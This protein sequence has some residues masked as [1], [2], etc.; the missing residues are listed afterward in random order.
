MSPTP[1]LTSLL[2][3]VR[4]VRV[5]PTTLTDRD[6]LDLASTAATLQHRA[7]TISALLA[8]EIARRSVG[9]DGLAQRLG[10]RTAIELVRVTTGSTGRDAAVAVRVGSLTESPVRDALVEGTISPSAADAI[11]T[12][13]GTPTAAVSADELAAA[14]L[15]LCT[16]DLDPD[17]LQRRA[18][19]VRAELDVTSIADREEA[20]RDARSLR[21][22]RQT[23]GMSK[24]IWLMDPETAATV[25]DVFDRATSPRLG[26]PRF[27]DPDTAAHAAAI[28]AD[29][30]T[31]EQLASDVFTELLRHGAAADSTQLLGSGAPQIRVLVAATALATGIGAATIEGQTEP[32][33]IATVERLACTG[34]TT[35]ITFANGQPLDVGRE[36][37]LYTPRQRIA[38]AARDGG[39]RWPRCDRPPSWTEAHHINHWAR[40]GGRTDVADG[41]LLCR[42]HHLQLHNRGW[43]IARKGSTYTLT[44]PPGV[45]RA[46]ELMPTKARTHAA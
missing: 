28:E 2:E 38:L 26:G 21:F 25:G 23:D 12:G 36:H 15:E 6:L 41:I 37:R 33:S 4:C 8:G 14:S 32:I 43:T 9:S 11:V 16:L 22:I 27:V 31:N 30:R 44:P 20:L 1:S 46:P 40:D 5:E 39:C 7:A 42:H 29:P 13:L 45:D 35:E 24:L 10:H 3:A 18:R 19:E 34:G 17:R